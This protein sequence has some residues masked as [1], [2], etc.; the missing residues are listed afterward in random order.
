MLALRFHPLLRPLPAVLVLL[1]A[2]LAAFP[3]AGQGAWVPL[4]PEGGTINAVTFAPSNPA[5]AYAATSGGG[6]FASTDGG[7]AWRRTGGELAGRTVLSLA[8]DPA[9]PTVAYAGTTDGVWKTASSGAAWIAFPRRL[10]GVQVFALAVDPAHRQGIYAGTDRG[11]FSS[12]D[13]G[14]RWAARNAG[15]P[16]DAQVR[17]LDVDPTVPGTLFAGI[18]SE[19]SRAG[20]FRSANGGATWSRVQGGLP[21]FTSWAGLARSSRTLYAAGSG[22]LFRSDDDGATWSR[23][24]G[25]TQLIEFPS[26]LAAGSDGTLY[27]GIGFAGVQAS[28]DRGAS[29]TYLGAT[30]AQGGSEPFGE[31]RT[32]A[33]APGAPGRVL[34]GTSGLGV[35]RRSGDLFVA[36]NRGLTATHITG[37]EVDPTDP[38]HLYAADF[39]AGIFES[40][41]VGAGGAGGAAGAT[42]QPRNA[43][44][45]AGASAPPVL[46]VESLALSPGNPAVLYAGFGAGFA[47]SSDGARSWSVA[48][49]NE[50]STP[51]AI[52][53]DPR[54][55]TVYAG[56]HPVTLHGCTLDCFAFES[57]DGGQ[58]WSCLPGIY[59]L[60][61]ILVDPH[62]PA[63][64]YVAGDN[65]LWKSVDRGVSFARANRDLG[66]ERVLSL[67]V[68]PA[69]TP[70]I[71]GGTATGGVW[72]SSDGAA[73]WAP[74]GAL[75]AGPVL[76]VAVD[77][78][79]ASRVYAAVRGAGVFASSD[80]GAQ[81]RRL[82]TLPG[83]L[84]DVLTKSLRISGSSPR[85]LYAG[86]DGAG[87]W[88]LTLP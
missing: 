71:Y 41:D 1:I 2:L 69:A 59:Q 44:L 9:D 40:Q 78:A 75:P 47:R 76:G 50:C 24:P 46:S 22:S 27:V 39:S 23:V 82:G 30:G 81:W 80:G 66:Q 54:S 26:A 11:V 63:V 6:V 25:S 67:G 53:V 32:L 42:W 16:A 28:T 21:P 56:G 18:D 49:I 72:K 35:F 58:T 36:S 38:S 20:L 88:A 7:L 65:T 86:T 48:E 8:V 14:R 62:R 29:F 12:D 52:A 33:V 61:A 60:D 79:N 31:V 83:V 77:P 64:V 15:L 13:G 51:T 17:A 34:A 5:V 73:H 84:P 70:V 37:V 3:V 55:S 85:V 4:G 87:V 19:L 43:G 57:R 68:G 45:L 10:A 74:T